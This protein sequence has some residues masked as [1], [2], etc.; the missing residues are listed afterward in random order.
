[1]HYI[2]KYKNDP[3]LPLQ[4]INSFYQHMFEKLMLSAID[5]VNVTALVRNIKMDEIF[6]VF[7]V[8]T[9]STSTSSKVSKYIFRSKSGEHNPTTEFDTS[10]SIAYNLNE[11]FN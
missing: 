8:Y 6:D 4:S 3:T 7:D 1:M 9:Y 2:A 10:I 11:Y 5:V